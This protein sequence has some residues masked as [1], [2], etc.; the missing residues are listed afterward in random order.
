M[1]WAVWVWLSVCVGA[2]VSYACGDDLNECALCDVL[3][4]GTMWER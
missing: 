4:E 3:C 1:C 2:S